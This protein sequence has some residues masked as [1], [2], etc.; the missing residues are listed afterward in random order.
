MTLNRKAIR[1]HRASGG[2]NRESGCNAID[3]G[4][5]DG[6]KTTTAPRQRCESPNLNR[7]NAIGDN[8]VSGWRTE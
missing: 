4:T 5:F 2:G 1:E 8:R 6:I 7:S 3:N